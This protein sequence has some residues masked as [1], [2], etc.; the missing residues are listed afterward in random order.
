LKI[1][2]AHDAIQFAI[3]IEENGEAFYRR[4][5]QAVSDDRVKQLFGRLADEEAKHRGVFQEMLD[6]LD[7][8]PVEDEEEYEGEYLSYLRDYIDGKV[9]FCAQPGLTDAGDAIDFA[10]QRE[11]D[12]LLYYEELKKLVAERHH[13]L[14]DV[15]IQEEAAHFSQLSEA[16][17]TFA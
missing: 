9:V 13:R 17:R 5:G 11:L 14:L 10:I 6:G 4:A 16:R 8:P 15:V 1:F 7:A 2:D 12:S 3:R